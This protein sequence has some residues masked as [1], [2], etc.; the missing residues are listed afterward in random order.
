MVAR[1]S[2][3]KLSAKQCHLTLLTVLKKL[4]K[5]DLKEIL[6]H[7]SDDSI[8]HICEVLYNISYSQINMPQSKKR[9]LR[10]ILEEHRKV[11]NKITNRAR[12]V[13]ERR[14][15]LQNQS[16]GS[17]ANLLTAIVPVLMDL[18]HLFKQKHS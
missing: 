9:H 16:G 18:V 1:A 2:K 4:K 13:T 3:M 14:K 6:L 8:D 5:D 10:K 7:L 17:F 12:P 11:Y 15:L